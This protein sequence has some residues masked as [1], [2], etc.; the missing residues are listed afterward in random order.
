M[1]RLRQ[2]ESTQYEGRTPKRVRTLDHSVRE[3]T[4][5]ENNAEMI[6]WSPF[7]IIRIMESY[8]T[9]GKGFVEV[10]R[11]ELLFGFSHKGKNFRFGE[12]VGEELDFETFLDS[13]E[14]SAVRHFDE[15][16]Q[17]IEKAANKIFSCRWI[18]FR[19]SIQHEQ[20]CLKDSLAAASCE[21]FTLGDYNLPTCDFCVV[22]V[23]IDTWYKQLTKTV[24]THA[25]PRLPLKDINWTYFGKRVSFI[26]RRLMDKNIARNVD[27]TKFAFIVR[28]YL[29]YLLSVKL[30]QDLLRFGL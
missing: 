18:L 12:Y 4:A 14:N 21:D 11:Y 10:A 1:N 13:F 7:R 15:E 9:V 6:G 24:G 22:R 27:W 30:T 17:T 20:S 19:G 28:A 2:H 26:F 16:I 29:L 23:E 8:K 25:D 5:L 3:S